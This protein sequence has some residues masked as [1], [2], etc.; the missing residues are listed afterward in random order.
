MYLSK[1]KIMMMLSVINMYLTKY[2]WKD[3][4]A[5]RQEIIE[6]LWEL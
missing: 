4:E 1:K 5:L 6:K 3:L 2:N